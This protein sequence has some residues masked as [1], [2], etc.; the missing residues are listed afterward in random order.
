MGNRNSEV[1][2][3][4]QSF[5]LMSYAGLITFNF[6]GAHYGFYVEKQLNRLKKAQGA[7]SSAKEGRLLLPIQTRH[8]SFQALRAG[9]Q[10]QAI[11]KPIA[12][13]TTARVFFQT[14]MS[15]FGQ[16][17]HDG[18]RRSAWRL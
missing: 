12:A 10:P 17:V 15:R 3:S 7:G 8:S 14:P 1:N 4:N 2:I 5:S 16:D 13:L 18:Q 9:N 11:A 6:S